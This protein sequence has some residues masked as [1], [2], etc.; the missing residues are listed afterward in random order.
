MIRSRAATNSART[1]QSLRSHQDQTS[2]YWGFPGQVSTPWPVCRTHM[3]DIGYED[4]A[5]K[6]GIAPVTGS[7]A[8]LCKYA[9]LVHSAFGLWSGC[10]QASLYLLYFLFSSVFCIFYFFYL[11]WGWW[12]RCGTDHHS[13]PWRLNGGPNATGT[14]QVWLFVIVWDIIKSLYSVDCMKLLKQ[15]HAE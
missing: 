1:G 5:S 10:D 3:H 12:L 8:W 11:Q 4:Y 13:I 6:W 9:P 7:D 15:F 2:S 14:G